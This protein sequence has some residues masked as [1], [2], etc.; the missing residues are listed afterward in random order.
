[1]FTKAI[2]RFSLHVRVFVIFNLKLNSYDFRYTCIYTISGKPPYEKLS[3]N[4]LTNDEIADKPMHLVKFY[5][6][7]GPVY[8][9]VI[10][11]RKLKTY[12]NF[13]VFFC[14]VYIE[15]NKINQYLSFIRYGHLSYKV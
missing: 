13:D 5:G 4:H 12:L 11:F 9:I 8:I 15:V 10:Y 2:A 1:M 7:A 6:M 14:P 3:N